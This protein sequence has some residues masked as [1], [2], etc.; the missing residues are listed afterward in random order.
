MWHV[1]IDLHR[2][3]IMVAAVNDL[4]EI[5]PAKRFCCNTSAEIRTYFEELRP[6]R[7]V[8]EATGTYRWLLHL[9]A[10]L[11]T[12]FLAHPL[13]L[14]AMLRLLGWR[15]TDDFA[16]FGDVLFFRRLAPLRLGEVF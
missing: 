5:R 10:P 14:R 2:A 12:V 6:F 11:G 13:R 9:L 4:G 16:V 8:I 15:P 3:T 1:G 7:A